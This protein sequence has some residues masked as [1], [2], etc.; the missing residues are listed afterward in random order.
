M[1]KEKETNLIHKILILNIIQWF[2]S[3]IT[4][5]SY[6]EYLYLY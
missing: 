3:K 1:L 2:L 6:N 5:L 4:F